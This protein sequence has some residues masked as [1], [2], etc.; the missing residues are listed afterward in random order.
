MILGHISRASSSPMSPLAQPTPLAQTF[1]QPFPLTK[2]LSSMASFPT[3]PTQLPSLPKQLQPAPPS[4]P[5][6][7]LPPLCF[8]A[9]ESSSSQSEQSLLEYG[10]SLAW[11]RSRMGHWA[12]SGSAIGTGEWL[13]E[14]KRGLIAGYEAIY[15]TTLMRRTWNVFDSYTHLLNV[16]SWKNCQDRI[17]KRGEGLALYSCIA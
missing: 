10:P 6:L 8:P 5:L 1:N 15:F 9:R 3:K 16:V 11:L 14:R 17:Q 13:R 12:A 2:Q 7:Q 4:L